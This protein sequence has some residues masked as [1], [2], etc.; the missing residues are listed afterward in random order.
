MKIA[1]ILAFLLFSSYSHAGTVLLTAFEPFGGAAKNGSGEVA[2]ELAKRAETLKA[3]GIELHTCI[4]PV[5]YDRG[6]EVAKECYRQLRRADLVLS[7]GEAACDLRLE[8]R[9]HNLDNTPGFADNA[10]V[11]RENQ[12]IVPGGVAE[13]PSS[14]PLADMF[15]AGAGKVSVNPSVDP[16]NY[17]CN[18]TAYRL[19]NYF[20]AARIPY[21]FV[22]VPTASCKI[23]FTDTAD[24]V[25]RMLIS[26]VNALAGSSRDPNWSAARG[27]FAES[28]QPV[29]RA[30]VD[31]YLRA[32]GD[33][34]SSCARSFYRK[35][36]GIY[37][38]R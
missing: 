24:Q 38:N 7:L 3:K 26:A 11:I 2:Q 18:G 22:H 30:E 1:V 9:F 4:L 32:F 8:T 19:Q 16:G 17:V 36:S 27:R 34:E 12:P 13:S 35:L 21:G 15:C 25:E 23:K 37:G 6:A 28:V 14:L 5:E 10:D 33:G 29:V 20:R 31:A